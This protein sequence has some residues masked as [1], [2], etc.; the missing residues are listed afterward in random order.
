M[1]GWSAWVIVDGSGN[2][3]TVTGRGQFATPIIYRFRHDDLALFTTS[4]SGLS[5]ATTTSDTA[6]SSYSTAGTTSGVTATPIPTATASTSATAAS[7]EKGLS[8]GAQAGIGVGVAFGVLAVLLVAALLLW[9]RHRKRLWAKSAD[10]QLPS[11]SEKKVALNGNNWSHE[12]GNERH[13]AEMG[14]P[15]PVAELDGA[16]RGWEA[17]GDIRGDYSSVHQVR[18]G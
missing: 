9:R 5:S 7:T 16:W 15:T 6:A 10:A 8:T 17:S 1:F 4:S 2:S 18:S 11:A 13:I 12:M 14:A 3:E